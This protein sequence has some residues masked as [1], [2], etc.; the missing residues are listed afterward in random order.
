[1]HIGKNLEYLAC[2]QMLDSVFATLVQLIV[3]ISAMNQESFIN[4]LLRL[5]LITV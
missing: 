2:I 1:M 5:D 3:S 4:F